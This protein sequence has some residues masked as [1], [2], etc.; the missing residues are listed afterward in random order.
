MTIFLVLT[1]YIVNTNKNHMELFA[2]VANML[3]E[4][5]PLAYLFISTKADAVP[6][7]KQMVLIAWMGA[8]RALGI[9]PKF[10][11]SDKGQ[12]EINA[13]KHVWPQAKHQLC[14][15]HILRALKR[16]L[17]QNQNPGSYSAVEVH[18]A[19]PEIDL[20]FVPLGQI[21]TNEKVCTL[22][23]YYLWLILVVQIMISPP[24]KKLLAWIHLCVN[25]KATVSTLNIK[26]TLRIPKVTNNSI[27]AA[28]NHALVLATNDN[29]HLGH[30]N[31]RPIR[32]C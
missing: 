30:S 20:S 4:G 7:T 32:P 3:G 25:R 16:H 6:H 26:L 31:L 15:W 18:D 14:L 8:I 5:L 1:N 10:T 13:L 22:L 11:L 19:F 28:G 29:G 24:P 27:P 23:H 9:D 2:S 12:S 17:S 21:S